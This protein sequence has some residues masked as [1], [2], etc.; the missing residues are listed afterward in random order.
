[1]ALHRL[2]AVQVA[3]ID[4][5][6]RWADGGGLYF[7]ANPRKKWTFLYM[8]GGRRREIGLGGYPAVSLKIAR[9]KAAMMREQLARG[10]DPRPP[11]GEAVLKAERTFGEA[12]EATIKAKAPGWKGEKTEQ[13]WRRSLVVQ[14]ASLKDKAVDAVDTDDVLAVVLP[15]WTEMPESGGKL[16][17]RIEAVLDYA[18]SRGWRSGE[19]PARWRGHLANLLPKRQKLTRGHHRAVPYED[20]PAAFQRIAAMTSSSAR[21]LAFVILTA[22]RE[23]R[24]RGALWGEIDPAMKLWTAPKTKAEEEA[25]FEIPLSGA[26]AAILKAMRPPKGVDAGALIFPSQRKLEKLTN[27]SLGKVLEA[28]GL[29]EVSTT[30][31]WRST[32]RDWAGDKTD[33]PDEIVELAL[34]HVV[35]DETRRAYRRREALEK[36]RVLMDDWAAYLMQ[37]LAASDGTSQTPSGDRRRPRF[38]R[39]S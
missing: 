7:V 36:R 1:M 29:A 16:R 24:A 9:E 17:E 10:E 22:V 19:N 20:A 28:A 25:V 37:P 3:K 34:G 35:G 14:A 30:H 32:F 13:G 27:A 11:P 26:A 33:H 8:R 23:H 2:S 39:R 31:G 38:A 4:K 21:L 15:I 12:A 6:G 18:K 5:P